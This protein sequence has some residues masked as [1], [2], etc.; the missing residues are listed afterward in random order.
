MIEFDNVCVAFD[1]RKIIENFSVTFRD[2]EFVCLL[3]VS[4][5]G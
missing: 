4:G 5:C 3:G 1:G 2:G